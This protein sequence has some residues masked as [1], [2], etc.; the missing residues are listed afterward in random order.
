MDVKFNTGSIF[1]KLELRKDFLKILI[2]AT[3]FKNCVYR[4][5]KKRFSRYCLNNILKSIYLKHCI[6]NAC[7]FDSLASVHV[8]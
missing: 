4:T 7:A 2:M 3:S 5:L 8:C 1:E 6:M